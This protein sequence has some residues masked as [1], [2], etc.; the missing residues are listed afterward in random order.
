MSTGWTV[1]I[2]ASAM[3]YLL[4]A[5]APLALGDRVLPGWLT[6][7]TMLLPAALLAALVTTSTFASGKHLQLDA[8]AVGLTA[9]GIALWRKKNFVVAVVAAAFTTAVVRAIT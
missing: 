9:A 6:R 8:R 2:V 5:A 7:L 3:V 4:K 1:I